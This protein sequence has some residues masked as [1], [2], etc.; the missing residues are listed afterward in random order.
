MGRR[1][2]T[3]WDDIDSLMK[4]AALEALRRYEAQGDV[5]PGAMAVQEITLGLTQMSWKVTRWIDEEIKRKE[6][7][8]A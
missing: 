3:V 5:A 2:K 7:I 8:H 4:K 6:A 1:K